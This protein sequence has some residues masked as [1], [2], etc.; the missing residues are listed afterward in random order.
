M[1]SYSM[2]DARN[3][4]AS[5][6]PPQP[7]IRAFIDDTRAHMTARK[8]MVDVRSPQEYTGEKLHMPD[9]REEGTWSPT[10]ASVNGLHT[11]G[12]FSPIFW[13][14]AAYVATMGRGPN[15]ATL[16]AHQSQKEQNHE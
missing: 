5:H 11:R 2:V 13:A 16:S 8:P 1:P 14:S 7:T 15:G 3:G 9:Y 6:A 10:V 4:S 12:S